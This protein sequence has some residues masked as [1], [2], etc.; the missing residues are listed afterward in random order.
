MSLPLTAQATLMSR[1]AG[2]AYYDTVLDITWLADANL[3][4]S[5]TFGVGGIDS[6]GL[7][8]WH[9]ANDWIGGMN[10]ASHLGFSDWRLPTFSP[11]SGGASFDTSFSNNGTTDFGYGATGVG[12]QTVAG[13][14]V[15]EMGWMYYGNL[16]NLGFC[17][18]NDA[19][20]GS[21]VEQPGWGLANTGPF[22]NL[23]SS[24]YWSGVESSSGSA[25]TFSFDKGDLNPDDMAFGTHFVWAVRSGDVEAAA[26]VPE[27]GTVV[28]LGAGLLALAGVRRGKRRPGASAL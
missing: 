25:W 5:N 7:M 20:P 27:P 3:A 15:S 23:H 1:F 6:L 26:S 10:A 28:M 24:G 18:P 9:T 12:W 21:C 22:S 4:A 17:T 2:Q 14:I 19:D 11:V 13:A 16:G 8:N